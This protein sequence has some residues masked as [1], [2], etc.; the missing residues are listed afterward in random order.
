MPWTFLRL[1]DSEIVD[2]VLRQPLHRLRE[3]GFDRRS[4]AAVAFD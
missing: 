2:I 4:I 3:D 1:D